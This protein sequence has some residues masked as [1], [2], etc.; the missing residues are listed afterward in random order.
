[1]VGISRMTSDFRRVYG[2][3]GGRN[4]IFVLEE[5]RPRIDDALDRELSR[6][7]AERAIEIRR[8]VHSLDPKFA[9]IEIA[10]T[11]YQ[12]SLS[13]TDWTS[14]CPPSSPWDLFS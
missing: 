13:A 4:M 5:L 9:L 7:I 6:M 12:R 3:V 14:T 1:M 10:I 8:D 11:I 2:Y